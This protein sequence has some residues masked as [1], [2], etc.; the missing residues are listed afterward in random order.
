[1]NKYLAVLQI[2]SNLTKSIYWFVE[3]QVITLHS[4]YIVGDATNIQ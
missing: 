2:I 3:F 4:N 1:M